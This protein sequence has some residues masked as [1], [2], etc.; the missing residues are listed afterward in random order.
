MNGTLHDE[1]AAARVDSLLEEAARARLTAAAHPAR[2]GF[3]GR[4]GRSIVAFGSW[5]G[6]C[7]LRSFTVSSNTR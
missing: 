6:G 4:L 5:I 2:L 3:R 1:M 7:K